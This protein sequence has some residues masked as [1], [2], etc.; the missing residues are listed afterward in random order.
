MNGFK[1]S[2]RMRS[3]FNFG[4]SA[5]FTTSTGKVQNIA[6]SR[7]TPRR[8]AAK[9]AEGGKIDSSLHS[10][11]EDSQLNVE[12]GPNGGLRPGFTRGGY[13]SKYADGGKVAPKKPAPPPP[14]PSDTNRKG[15]TPMDA[16]RGRQKQMADLGLKKG[17]VAR[18]AKGGRIPDHKVA[19]MEARK[20]VSQHV[21]T[22]APRGHKGL[23]TKLDGC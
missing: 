15:T 4:S 1:N 3:G 11:K 5:G 21:A 20:A 18:F 2:T 9:F 6:Y 19:A 13:A 10:F 14:P 8:K 12:H 22:P 17:G 23:G 16:L 7:K